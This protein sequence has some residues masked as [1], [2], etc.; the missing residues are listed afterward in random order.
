MAAPYAILPCDL[1]DYCLPNL[2]NDS[3]FLQEKAPFQLAP[4]LRPNCYS[5]CPRSEPVPTAQVPQGVPE[6]ALGQL[7]PARRRLMR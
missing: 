7:A 1:G 4:V 6:E 5:S 3:F 2:P